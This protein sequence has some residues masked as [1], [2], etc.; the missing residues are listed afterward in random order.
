MSINET[1]LF[2]RFLIMYNLCVSL[3]LSSFFVFHCTHENSYLFTYLLTFAAP[4]TYTCGANAT[5]RM[6]DVVVLFERI[7]V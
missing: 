4:C 1:L 5:E 6:Q 2:N 7:Q 3:V